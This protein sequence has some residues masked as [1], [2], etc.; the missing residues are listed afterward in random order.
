MS[1]EDDNIE[2][3]VLPSDD[4]ELKRELDVSSLLP[5]FP[6]LSSPLLQFMR[7]SALEFPE[8]FVRISH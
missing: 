6:F 7:E 8:C 3:V 4:V 2:T 5:F 1:P